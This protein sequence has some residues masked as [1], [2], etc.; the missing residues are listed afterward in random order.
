M[1]R[2]RLNLSVPPNLSARIESIAT[3]YG[4][5]STCELAV[6]LLNVFADHVERAEVLAE[7]RDEQEDD[8]SYIQRIFSEMSESI[9]VPDGTVPIVHPKRSIK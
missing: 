7:I 8:E 1:K 4:F 5:V 2:K 3:R 6:T 9:R